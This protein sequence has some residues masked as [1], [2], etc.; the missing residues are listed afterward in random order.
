MSKL[1]DLQQRLSG[2][3]V[4]QEVMPVVIQPV[5]QIKKKKSKAGQPTKMT[6][7][8]LRRIE[9]VASLGG[10]VEEMA[11]FCDIHKDTIY[12]YLKENPAYSDKLDRLSERPVLKARNTAVAALNDV[13]SAHWY[14]ER[15]RPKE[16]STKVEVDLTTKVLQIDI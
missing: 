7:D 16:F 10:S 9:E 8:N 4:K 5:V 2:K 1:D 12:N 11:S 6:P 15:K 14:L 3:P 13:G